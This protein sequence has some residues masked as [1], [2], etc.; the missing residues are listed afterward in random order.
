M[1][2][3]FGKRG[4]VLVV[5]AV[6]EQSTDRQGNLLLLV[7][8]VDDLSLDNL[9]DLESVFR[10]SD[11]VIRDLGDVDQTVNARYD[12]SECAERH[13]LEDLN[14]SNRADVVLGLEYVP[15]IV[16]LALVAEGDLLVL[17]VQTD[18]EYLDLV[19]NGND[20]GRVLDAAP[21]QLGHA[22]Y[23]AD[24][25]K[26]AVGGQGLDNTVV[27]VADLDGVPDLLSSSLASLLLD[28]TD[29]TNN[30]LAL[31]VDLGDIEG[32]LGLYQR[33]HRLILRNAGLR[34]RDEYAN[35]V[36]SCNDTAAVLLYDGALNNGVLLVCLL[37]GLPALELVYALLGQGN[38]ALAVVY[39]D[40]NSL[41]LVANVDVGCDIVVR[42]IGQLA[43]RDIRSVLNA[44]IDLYVVVG[45][46]YN[47][48]GYLF[49]II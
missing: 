31:T 14:L 35:A 25:Y 18:Y 45:N 4:L 17:L 5:L 29:R 7:V 30:A 42:V 16:L 24:V 41:D 46:A 13:E 49:S 3:R 32:L 2:L 40:N 23:A 47:G 44:Q 48:A 9:A 34:S 22:V 36:C 6:L 37:Y 8:D 43:Q 15:R 20:L 38:S 21:G 11:A 39:A 1:H 27:L 10:L 19:A 33:A 12:L 26:C 28:L